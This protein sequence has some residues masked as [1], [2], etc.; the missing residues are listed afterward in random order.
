MEAKEFLKEKHPVTY[1][2]IMFNTQGIYM[3]AVINAMENFAAQQQSSPVTVE[4]INNEIQPHAITLERG[5]KAAQAVYDLLQ[6]KSHSLIPQQGEWIPVSERLPET[7]PEEE[8]LGPSKHNPPWPPEGYFPSSGPS[9]GEKAQE[10]YEKALEH[11]ACRTHDEIESFVVD[12]A[13]RIAAGI[14]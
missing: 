12:E 9:E 10:R 4:E 2:A 8:R 3:D 14:S 7:R 13:L 11:Y 1:D 6:E 5:E